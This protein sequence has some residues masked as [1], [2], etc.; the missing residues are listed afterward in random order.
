MKKH[1]EF[2]NP[3]KE[4][5]ENWGTAKTIITMIAV[6]LTVILSMVCYYYEAMLYFHIFV[7]EGIA[8]AS[9][10]LYENAIEISYEHEEE[11][12]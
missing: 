6:V 8:L 2:K 4:S 1:I 7:V 3:W 12:E 11:G 5:K 9:L 10:F